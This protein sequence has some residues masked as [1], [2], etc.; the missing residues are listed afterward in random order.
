MENKEG[1]DDMESE[2]RRVLEEDD[3]RR[4]PTP[5]MP[6]Q[7]R[8]PP[9]QDGHWFPGLSRNQPMPSEMGSSMVCGTPVIDLSGVGMRSAFIEAAQQALSTARFNQIADFLFTD[10]VVL[11]R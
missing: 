2:L 11:Q 5:G 9:V 10:K 1:L 7:M 3:R 6:V 4:N 8:S